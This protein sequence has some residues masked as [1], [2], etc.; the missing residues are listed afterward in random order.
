VRYPV[1]APAGALSGGSDALR[2]ISFWKCD[3]PR[4]GNGP[5]RG[6]ATA[7]RAPL[8]PLDL[9]FAGLIFALTHGDHSNSAGLRRQRD[10][11]W[12][13]V[14]GSPLGARPKGV[15]VRCEVYTSHFSSS[16]PSQT[17]FQFTAFFVSLF[18]LL[19]C[20][21]HRN[22]NWNRSWS[23]ECALRLM[24]L[25]AILYVF[26]LIWALAHSECDSPH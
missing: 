25:D 26:P 20:S 11:L 1:V 21:P 12:C 13:V 7:L 10:S 5:I 8:D 2:H 14:S 22:M 17:E 9:G 23:W 24:L 15:H 4:K 18:S 6:P 16:L 3:F 19:S